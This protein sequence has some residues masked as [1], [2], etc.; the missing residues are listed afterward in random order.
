MRA[1]TSNTTATDDRRCRFRFFASL[2]HSRL[3]VEH[4]QTK[5]NARTGEGTFIP[6]RC[7][8]SNDD[9]ESSFR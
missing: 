4:G 7:P 6:G 8:I 5:S 9:L 3:S 1:L 2:A